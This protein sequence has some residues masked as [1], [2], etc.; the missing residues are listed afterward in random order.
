MHIFDSLQTENGGYKC[1]GLHDLKTVDTKVSN[2]N[3]LVCKEDKIRSV[4][5]GSETEP[6]EN[7]KTE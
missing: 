7:C 6:V 1:V 4:I 5:E 3:G 2:L